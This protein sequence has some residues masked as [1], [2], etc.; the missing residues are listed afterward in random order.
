[1]RVRRRDVRVRHGPHLIA[2]CYCRDC[3]KASG[4]AFATFFG[5]AEDDF[6]LLSGRPKPFHDWIRPQD[7]PQFDSMPS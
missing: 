4:G 2:D 6:T 5:V 7:L 1:M 3:R